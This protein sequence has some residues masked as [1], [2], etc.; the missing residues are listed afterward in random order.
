MCQECFVQ[1]VKSEQAPIDIDFEHGFYLEL[2]GPLSLSP[3]EIL[4]MS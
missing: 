2:K 3:L 1:N 4:D